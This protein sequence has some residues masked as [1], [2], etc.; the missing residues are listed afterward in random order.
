MVYISICFYIDQE[1]KDL[2]NNLFDRTK[3]MPKQKG[4]AD[5]GVY[6]IAVAQ[7]SCMAPKFEI[8]RITNA[9]TYSSL[10]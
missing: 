7:H 6:A 5:C 8:F 2:I 9:N 1:V 4:G 10:L 3:E